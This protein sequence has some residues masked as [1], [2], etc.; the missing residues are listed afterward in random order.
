M[1]EPGLVC[2]NSRLFAKIHVK[3]TL[4]WCRDFPATFNKSELKQWLS[5]IGYT[6]NAPKISRE[7][8]QVKC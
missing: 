8:C 7:R 2:L 6:Q 3:G 1:T 4:S 5:A